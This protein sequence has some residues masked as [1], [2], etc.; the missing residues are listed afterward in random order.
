MKTLFWVIAEIV[1]V[2]LLLSMPGSSFHTTSKWFG[3]FPIDKLVHIV[4]FGS[5]AMSF[6]VHFEQSTNPRLQTV[7]AKALVLIF[8]ILYG[9][10]MEFY[11][12]FF[13]P[14]RGFEVS[15]MLADAIGAILAIPMLSWTK[16]MLKK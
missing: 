8:C 12:K 15:D 4:L 3:D 7:R 11:Q 2:F 5:L 13:V 1:V 6:F 14:S 10:A 9:I 16:K